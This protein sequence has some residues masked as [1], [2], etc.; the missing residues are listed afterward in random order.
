MN[1]SL[2]VLSDIIEV[3]DF[4]GWGLKCDSFPLGVIGEF[5]IFHLL[6][7]FSNLLKKIF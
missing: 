6:Y 5:R 2:L 4:L 7:L 3:D 1:R